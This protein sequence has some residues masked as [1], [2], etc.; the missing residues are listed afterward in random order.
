MI[1]QTVLKVYM[2]VYDYPW[3]YPQYKFGNECKV[4]QITR[5]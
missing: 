2:N 4:G 3:G 5:S 1:I